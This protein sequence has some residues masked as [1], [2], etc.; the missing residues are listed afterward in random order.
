MS[1]PGQNNDMTGLF[2]VSAVICALTAW[3]LFELASE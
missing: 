3:A 2:Y 1:Q